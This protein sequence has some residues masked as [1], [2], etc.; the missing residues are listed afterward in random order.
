MRRL[1]A[2][3]LAALCAAS[4]S[5]GTARHRDEAP[6]AVG[7]FASADPGSV[8]TYWLQ[9]PQGLV[10]VDTQRSLTDAR[11]ALAA[12]E[13]TGVPIAAILITHSHPDHVGGVG[14]SERQQPVPPSML[15]HPSTPRCVPT[16]CT[17]TT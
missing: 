16:R 2:L 17:S 5:S 15:R 11:A 9:A 13:A 12:V 1:A 14:Y 8:N 7:R 3:L 10:V 6:P 4:C